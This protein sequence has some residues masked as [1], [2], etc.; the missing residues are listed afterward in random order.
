MISP[1][2]PNSLTPCR[3]GGTFFSDSDSCATGSG[4][5]S[6]ARL[7]RCRRF[8]SK[9]KIRPASRRAANGIPRPAPRPIVRPLEV[10]DEGAGA[11]TCRAA[12]VAEEELGVELGLMERVVGI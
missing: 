11:L 5:S 10:E 6:D 9:K 8:R 7:A 2:L 4:L 1:S 3:G 12:A